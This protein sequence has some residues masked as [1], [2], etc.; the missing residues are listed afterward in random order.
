MAD[1]REQYSYMVCFSID[2]VKFG[3][4]C[5]SLLDQQK[6][7]GLNAFNNYFDMLA[8]NTNA[9]TIPDM[10]DGYYR[11]TLAQFGSNLDPEQL[12]KQFQSFRPTINN[13]EIQEPLF[14]TQ[15]IGHATHHFRFDRNFTNKP[16]A[17]FMSCPSNFT[18]DTTL[19]K[20]KDRINDP[21]WR[22]IPN[23]LLHMNI[24]L[25]SN[26][27][28]TWEKIEQY[29]IPAKVIEHPIEVYHATLEIIPSR[30]TCKAVYGKNSSNSWW[31]GAT[32]L[33]GRCSSC[34]YYDKKTKWEGTDYSNELDTLSSKFDN[35]L[36]I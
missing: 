12:K 1:D 18:F 19:K 7:Q 33:Y 36:H 17:L 32:Q 21:E 2:P 30:E 5:H 4:F 6:F 15:K 20:I 31:E 23:N 25:Y 34:R 16:I 8:P 11:I 10:W 28:S 24:R 14:K 35:K 27:R 9:K 22:G 3:F 26:A 13:V 29:D